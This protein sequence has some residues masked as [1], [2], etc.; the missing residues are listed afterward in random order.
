MERKLAE[1]HEKL[2]SFLRHF[3]WKDSMGG[4]K[5]NIVDLL[6]TKEFL[7]NIGGKYAVELVKI[8]EKKKKAITDDEIEKKLPLK[9]TEVRTILNRLHYRGI[10]TY[11][12]TRNNKTGWY[13]YTWQISTAR[14][15]ALLLEKQLEEIQRAE[16]KMEF[17]TNYA[18][19]TCKTKCNNFPFEIAAEYQF[20][21]PGCGN[22]LEATDNQKT[23]KDMRKKIVF[24]KNEM[25]ELTKHC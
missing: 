21:C 13:S 14:I 8:C 19:F 23:L 20:K 11:Q 17:E 6:I 12:K 10:A 2:I 22:S 3:K 7:M 24:M 15:A 9:I 5:Q 1:R 16:T 18:F 25:D 4:R